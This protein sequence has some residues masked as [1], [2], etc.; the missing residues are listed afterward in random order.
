MINDRY[1]IISELGEG[2]S[3]V[4]LCKDSDFGNKEIAVKFLSPKADDEEWSLFKD[5]FFILQKLEHPG[6]VRSYEIGAAVK[7]DLGD[8]VEIGSPFITLE[9]FNSVELT[10]YDLITDK[11]KLKEIL[12]QLCSALYYLHQS[13]YIY[14]DLKPE[15]I[16]I[17]SEN[18]SLQIKLIDLGLAEFIPDRE[19]HII[20][21]TAQYIAPELLKKEPHDQRVDLYS[22]GMLLY[23]IIYQRLPFDVSDEIDI[24]KA[25][26]EQEFDFPEIPGIS[27]G[28]IVITEKLLKKDPSERYQNTLQVIADLE[29]EVSSN[30][31]QN[32][33]PAK[34]FSGRDDLINILTLYIND[35]SSSEV[36][37][38]KGFDGAGRS[39]LLNKIYETFSNSVLISNTQGISGI[40]LIK[41]IVKKITYSKQ[42]YLNL[43]ENDRKHIDDFINKNQKKFV[44]KLL[45]ILSIITA[46]S[47]FILL[48]D[49][50]N[51][52][53]QFADNIIKEMIP[54][55]QVNNIKVI[56]SESS[57]F[58]YSSKGIN[59]LREISIGSFVERQ[60]SEYLQLAFYDQFPREALKDLILDYADLLPGNI[61]GFIRD[62]INLNIIIFNPDNVVIEKNLEKLSS[63]EGSITAI[64]DM[65]LGNL[66]NEELN[67]AKLISAFESNQDQATLKKFLDLEQEKLNDLLSTLQI[68]NIIQSISANTVPVISSDGLKKHIYSLIEDKRE[69]HFQ[70]AE[71]I[72]SSGIT[73]NRNEFAR[74]YELAGEFEKALSIW[75]EELQNAEE[76]SA[77]SYVRTILT[78]TLEFQLSETN[79]NE[80][81]YQLVETYFRLNDYNSVLE[82]IDKV[83]TEKL[84][85][86]K[87]LELFVLKGSSQI[88]S[89]NLDEGLEVLNS[90]LPEVQDEF[91][92]NNLLVEIAYAKFD[93]NKF[94]EVFELGNNILES[95]YVSDEDRG[96]VHNLLGM[97]IAFNDEKSND[98]LRHLELSL[99]FFTKANLVAKV[100]SAEVNLGIINNIRNNKEKAEYHWNK[101][102]K[103]SLSVGDLN[104]EA[105]ILINTGI[106][107]FDSAEYEK[108]SLN[109]ERANRIFLSLGI[110]RNQ[111]LALS[112]LGEVYLFSCEYEKSYRALKEAKEIF[113]EMKNY[114]ELVPVYLLTAQLYFTIGNEGSLIELDKKV[115]GLI[116][117]NKLDE[118]YKQT[119]R[120]VHLL[121]QLCTNKDS[122]DIDEIIDL[123]N[124]YFSSEE[125]KNYLSVQVILVNQLFYRKQFHK[126]L[127]Q[128]NDENYLKSLGNNNVYLANRE[129]LL[130]QLASHLEFDDLLTPIEYYEKAYNYLANQ[131]IVEL[132]WKVLL[133]LAEVYT[134]RGLH[135]KAKNFIVYARDLINL[136]AEN[137]ESI[138]MKSTYLHQKERR[139]ALEKLEIFQKK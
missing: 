139:A 132:T 25:Q 124:S 60:L 87:A 65:R 19:E 8:P 40:D 35:K 77:Y 110:A 86:D 85:A 101:A 130:G 126:A 127:K 48:I 62:M 92:K 4:Y 135:N 51:L 91:R 100:A 37:T 11:L 95:E 120:H 32:F 66:N 88:N 70:L 103:S 33:M 34:V 21:G 84:T 73:I 115:T 78:H 10:K 81:R 98:A 28:F 54:A 97:C 79:K 134:E 55:F 12:I 36:F 136:I 113:E 39:S 64:Y 53:D 30:I 93:L 67:L 61:I 23:E 18:D 82:N 47:K 90:L 46:K 83:D 89:G 44:E 131:S 43:N 50:Y 80:I 76:I 109:Y 94:D 99:S 29:M 57:D 118:R 42:V 108:A 96:R 59:N 3:K 114:E 1:E 17:S 133:A 122:V 102:L 68:N 116:T 117:E 106:L 137:I 56:I 49:D 121:V 69:F 63:I 7:I 14:Y 6:I 15:N 26:V 41:F 22:L 129:Y 38:I 119:Q 74:Q 31:Y 71:A 5:E 104:Q 52:F 27:P 138:Q 16:L 112:N 9:Y 2:R 75:K 72:S 128:L 45:S 105:L 111:G 58:N 123:R 13:N 20:K 24:Y 107:H 125:I